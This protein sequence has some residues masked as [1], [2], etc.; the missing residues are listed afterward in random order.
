MNTGL[1]DFVS[2]IWIVAS[3]P[4]SVGDLLGFATGIAC[5]LLAARAHIWNFPMGI[6]NSAILA[7]VFYQTRLFGDMTLQGVFL[8][9]SVQGWLEWGRL[10]GA[11]QAPPEN[12]KKSDHLWGIVVT[13]IAALGIR[14][15]LVQAG[16]A[17]PW[18]DAFITASSLWAQWLLNRKS[19]ACWP[20][21]IAVDLVSVPLYWSR[22]LPLIA[23][24]YVVFLALCLQGWSRWKRLLSEPATSIGEVG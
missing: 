18:P 14:Q 1:E 13:L 5:V 15:I 22:H 19:I 24:L 17:A 4:I 2:P 21:W 6:A 23:A 7:L 11:A 9:L 10:P 8:A 12:A 3:S 16:G 20:W